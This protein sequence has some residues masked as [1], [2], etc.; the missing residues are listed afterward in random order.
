MSEFLSDFVLGA[1]E[2]LHPETGGGL[3][4]SFTRVGTDSRAVTPGELFVALRGDNF[5]G[6]AFIE[7]ALEAGAGAVLMDRQAAQALPAGPWILVDDTLAGLQAIAA[8]HI[9]ASGVRR[10]ALTGSNGKTSTKEMIAAV[11]RGA[12]GDDAV[13]A[14]R[15]NLNNHVGVPLTAFGIE[16]HHRAAV[17]EMGMNH[18][19]EIT[20]LREIVDPEIALITNIGTAHA[21]NVGGI[22]GVARAKGELF[23]GLASDAIAVVNADDARCVAQA[24]RHAGPRLTFGEAE[25]ADVRLVRVIEGEDGLT[26]TFSARGADA[27][28]HIAYLG[29]HNAAN[30]AGAVAVGLAAGVDLE[31]ACR[32]LSSV[33]PPAG[34]LRPRR[35]ACGA[36]VLDDTYNANPDS[37]KAAF[38][39]LASLAGKKRRVAAVG[40]MLEL[41]DEAPAAHHAIGTA[42]VKSGIT[43]IFACG[44]FADFTLE[45]ARSAGLDPSALVKAPDSRALAPLVA[46]A[47]RHDDALVVKGSRGARMERVVDAVLESTGTVEVSPRGNDEGKH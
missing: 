25:G 13:L 17:F 42:A 35:A 26:L 36:Y 2:P 44:T 23:D 34:R 7:S 39:T 18:H 16:P 33:V 11:M 32:G 5:D 40:D 22:E 27:T 24:A 14:T 20:R 41:G 12:L 43:R 45:G 37:M 21:G 28:A 8:R 19:G 29:R 31:T 15:G 6:H 38:V 47:L 1:L 46:N 4:A 3:P 10:I 30:A 9:A